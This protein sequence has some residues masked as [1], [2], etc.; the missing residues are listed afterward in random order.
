MSRPLLCPSYVPCHL[1]PRY[2]PTCLYSQ[3]V[4]HIMRA[5]KPSRYI[6]PRVWNEAS[7]SKARPSIPCPVRKSCAPEK[8]RVPMHKTACSTSTTELLS[9]VLQVVYPGRAEFSR[10]RD[11]RW[12][13]AWCTYISLLI[14]LL[15]VYLLLC[16]RVEYLLRK[17]TQDEAA[18]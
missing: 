18:D 1:S 13:A 3:S 14:Y 17:W 10:E 5:M 2:L 11:V 6:C 12:V 9:S 16:F 4:I 15:V 7:S 8:L